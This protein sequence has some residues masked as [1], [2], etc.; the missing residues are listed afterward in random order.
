MHG[1]VAF[2]LAGLGGFN[3]HG[4]GF[5]TAASEL[6]IRPRLVTATS[7]QIV[8]LADWLRGKDLKAQLARGDNGEGL[9]GTLRILLRGMPG[10]F[11]PALREGIARWFTWPSSSDSLF[12][13]FADRLM[14]AQL[15]VP[16]RGESFF[17]EMATL[18]NATEDMGIVFNAFDPATGEGKLF[19]NEAAKA[20]WPVGKKLA[21]TASLGGEV[22]VEPDQRPGLEPITPQALKAALWL[23]L[24]GFE[25]MPG[26]MIDGAY[27]RACIVSELYRFKTIFAVRP[28]AKGWQGRLPSNYF[29]VE[30]WQTE[31]WFSVG[32]KAEVEG[33]KRINDLIF[34]KK[35]VGGGFSY[36]DL[37]EI[38]PETPAGYFN[39]FT[40]RESV[41]DAAHVEGLAKLGAYLALQ[42]TVT[43]EAANA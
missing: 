20:C 13:A 26:R 39:Y 38:A 41:F 14:P 2:A 1:D 9:F 18:F 42:E 33:M 21:R 24:Y 31:M 34:D 3:A 12:D 27:H 35:L 23:S 7:G 36:I 29:D 30:D 37:V 19:G 15:Y 25:N 10:V 5:L 17:E 43:A 22:V 11:R 40:E 16:E 32:Y 28:L 8:V 6:G 4:A